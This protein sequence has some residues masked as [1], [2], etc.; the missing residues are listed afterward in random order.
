MGVRVGVIVVMLAKVWKKFDKTV[1]L[2]LE[3]C[4]FQTQN[5]NQNPLF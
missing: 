5:S 4:L 3:Q 1:V 2:V